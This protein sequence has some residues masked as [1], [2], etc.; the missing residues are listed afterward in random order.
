MHNSHVQGNTCFWQPAVTSP[1]LAV[2]PTPACFTRL[3]AH[4]LSPI[5]RAA[6][7]WPEANG[8]K[9]Y[10]FLYK[11]FQIHKDIKAK[12]LLPV[13]KTDDLWIALL[14]A[15]ICALR[16]VPVYDK[17]KKKYWCQLMEDTACQFHFL[18][19]VLFLGLPFKLITK[20]LK[21]YLNKFTWT[22]FSF[23]KQVLCYPSKGT[24][25]GLEGRWQIGSHIFRLLEKKA[26]LTAVSCTHVWRSKQKG[27]WV[28]LS[29]KQNGN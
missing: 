25:T 2:T 15:W 11:C 14:F 24:A 17:K 4:H 13:E 3:T 19:L 27:K 22:T 20:T 10:Q 29:Y 18:F 26:K 7:S 5:S 8:E 6:I 16:K 1:A 28:K 21:L 23:L 12:K 9:L